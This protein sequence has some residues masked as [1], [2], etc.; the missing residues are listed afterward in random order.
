MKKTLKLYISSIVAG[1][2]HGNRNI[3]YNQINSRGLQPVDIRFL[4]FTVLAELTPNAF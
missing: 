3:F 4:F 1:R 2:M